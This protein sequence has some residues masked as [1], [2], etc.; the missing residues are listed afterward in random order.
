MDCSRSHVYVFRYKESASKLLT[1]LYVSMY[2]L[3]AAGQSALVHTSQAAPN[4]TLSPT[5]R[6]EVGRA[7]T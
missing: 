7:D 1:I 6:A 3:L 5:L 4:S 2:I